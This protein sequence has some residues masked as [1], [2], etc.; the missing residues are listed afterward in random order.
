MLC[1]LIDIN[2]ENSGNNGREKELSE[3]LAKEYAKL[4][5]EADLYSPDSVPNIKA[6]PDY[7][8]GR[9]LEDR[10]NITVKLAGKDSKKSLMLAGHLDTMPIGDE[11]IWT[12]PPTKGTVK[13]GR[14]YGRGANDDKHALAIELFL[15]K[16]FRELGVKLNN[17]VYLSGYVDEEFGGGD[18]ALACCLKYPSDFY[19]NIDSDYM[20][21]IHSG[22]GGQRLAIELRH[23][24]PKDSC[25]DMIE[26]I[27]L[28]K[29]EIDEFG[30]RRKSEM[31][32]NALYK[33]TEIPEKSLRYMNVATGLN[34]TDR[35]RG[36]VDFAFYTDRSKEEIK[37]EL[38]E[39]F[40]SVSRAIEHLGIKLDNVIYRSRF[41]PFAAVDKGHKCIDL[42]KSCA[43]NALDRELLVK[44]MCLSDLNIFIKN[45]GG[46]A[47][48]CGACRGFADEGGAHQPD[49]YVLCDE[50][51][52]LTKLMVEFIF[53]WDKSND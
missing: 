24:D 16:A 22:V 31:S 6:H 34:T 33:D 29:K 21:I 8:E 2:T 19:I 37:I 47:I 14:I 1:R 42:L 43:K 51:V 27:Y 53:E 15:A 4:G 17:D 52:D 36:I 44:G 49:E 5:L 7:L 13:D 48:S 23:P 3:Y 50:L 25:E 30:K 26:A 35:N 40:E 9:N 11:S 46:N 38:N 39:L 41:F 45:S 12:M 10:P 18:G 32:K 28:T 20:D